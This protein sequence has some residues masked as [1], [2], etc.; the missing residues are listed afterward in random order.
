[1]LYIRLSSQQHRQNVQLSQT[2][3]KSDR[4]IQMQMATIISLMWKAAAAAAAE[5]RKE[6]C[7]AQVCPFVHNTRQIEVSY[8]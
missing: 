4:Y 1:M 7:E 8:K 2:S 5:K 6:I 3:K